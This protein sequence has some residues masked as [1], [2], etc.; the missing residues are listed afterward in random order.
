MG[1]PEVIRITMLLNLLEAVVTPF[2]LNNAE[3]LKE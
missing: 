1:A 2:T 3:P